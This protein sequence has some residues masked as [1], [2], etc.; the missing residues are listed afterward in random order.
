[1]PRSLIDI[2]ISHAIHATNTRTHR[3]GRSARSLARCNLVVAREVWP[4]EIGRIPPAASDCSRFWA[5]GINS[6]EATR[7]M[8]G[9]YT[10]ASRCAALPGGIAWIYD[11]EIARHKAGKGGHGLDSGIRLTSPRLAV[12]SLRVFVCPDQCRP[13]AGAARPHYMQRTVIASRR[14][15]PN[16]MDPLFSFRFNAPTLLLAPVTA[17]VSPSLSLSFF[18]LVGYSWFP[19]FHP[20]LRSPRLSSPFCIFRKRASVTSIFL[21]SRVDGFGRVKGNRRYL[22]R[23]F[24][25]LCVQ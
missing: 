14:A 1:M 24:V 2:I 5:S 18:A 13:Y 12:T 16:P 20:F 11:L 7:T 10:R 17:I 19:P 9:A 3:P 23:S 6:R 8:T 25:L 22:G 21:H 4:D 15:T